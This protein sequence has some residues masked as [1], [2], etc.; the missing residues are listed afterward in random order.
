MPR[1]PFL[2]APALILGCLCACSSTPADEAL[3]EVSAGEH[4]RDASLVTFD[5]P[6]G[7]A[8]SFLHTLERLDTG[9]QVP[10]Q[11]MSGEPGRVAW[12]LGEPLAAG[13]S[14]RYI[15]RTAPPGGTASPGA[16][17]IDERETVEFFA[18]GKP[19]LV[20]NRRFVEPPAGADPIYGRSGFLHPLYSPGGRIL[21]DD[22][23]PDH[24]HQHGIF[25]AWVNTTF[26]GREVDFW[27]QAK[28]QGD[29]VHFTLKEVR[30]GV[31]FAQLTV[32]LQHVDRTTPEHS[33]PAI[34]ETWT[35]RVYNVASPFL[36]DI[37]SEQ[38]TASPS[39][40]SINEYHYGGFAMRG[41]RE[42]FGQ[43]ESGMITS[44]GKG[45]EDGNH[46]RPAWVEMFGLVDGSPA[47]AVVFGSTD[48]FRYPQPVRLHGSKPYFCFAP[49]V[50][51][52]FS[53]E[54]GQVYV[55]RYRIATHDGA[56]D[57]EE[58]E[59]LWRDYSDPPSVRIVD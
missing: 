58:N 42:W 25:F 14:R 28:K 40:L 4:D 57:S 30:S 35:I 5:L 11:R 16:T 12:L 51:G 10:V 34:E 55:S 29:V 38:R 31:V 56:V 27:N 44:G 48:N 46:T 13:E 47:G 20:Y 36:I 22:F 37:V 45:V 41:A 43:P 59:R 1:F 2:L 24:Y 49:M 6:P 39:P 23:P 32:V 33:K 8:D 15:L 21:T 53:I 52:P 7:L 17:A 50:E 18:A 3:I 19:V 54:P 9:A 26:E